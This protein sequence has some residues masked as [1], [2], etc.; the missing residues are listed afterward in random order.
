MEKLLFSLTFYIYYSK[1]F[2]TFQI[3]F[4]RI[5]RESGGNAVS[6]KAERLIFSLTFY[7]NYN[8]NFTLYQ[9]LS[10]GNADEIADAARW[11]AA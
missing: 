9:I 3:I 8:K 10:C 4:F 11:D 5:L 1:I 6:L 2:R 7:N